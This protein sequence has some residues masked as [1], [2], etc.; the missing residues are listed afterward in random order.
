MQFLSGSSFAT[1][2]WLHH[3]AEGS[4]CSKP[5]SYLNAGFI[6]AQV[7]N[8]L[9][10]RMQYTSAYCRVAPKFANYGDRVFIWTL[11]FFH[12]EIP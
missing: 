2:Q 3:S 11:L 6:A 9:S 4:T 8:L 7:C 5:K 12:Q 1:K 10:T